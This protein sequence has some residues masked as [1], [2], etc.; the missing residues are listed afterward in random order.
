[1]SH[2]TVILSSIDAYVSCHCD[3]DEERAELNLLRNEWLLR[4]PHAV[5]LEVA[6][7]ELDFVNRWCWTSFGASDGECTQKFSEYRACDID[8]PH[9]HSGVWMDHWFEKTDYNFGFNEWYFADRSDY[10]KFLD[11]IPNI[12]WGGNYPK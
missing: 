10:D 2:R 12:N 9:A 7:P 6:Y 1:M 3:S 11:N 4:F 5:M 8:M